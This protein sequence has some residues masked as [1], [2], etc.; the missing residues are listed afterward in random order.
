MWS[1]FFRSRNRQTREAED[2]VIAARSSAPERIL[3]LQRVLGNRAVQRL[4]REQLN[5]GIEVPFRARMEA[6]FGEN[7]GNVR[8]HLGQSA[9]L[10]ELGASAATHG[11]Q[12]AFASSDPDPHVVAHELTHVVQARRFGAAPQAGRLVSNPSDSAETE[13]RTSADRAV[14]GGRVEVSSALTAPVSLQTPPLAHGYGSEWPPPTTAAAPPSMTVFEKPDA[15]ASAE[16][17]RNALDEYGKM[18]PGNRK[19]AFDHSFKTGS[20]TKV[21]NALPATDAAET[22][23]PQVR[24]LLGWMEEVDEAQ[25]RN[26]LRRIE[27]AETLKASGKSEADLAAMQAKFLSAPAQTAVATA[28]AY[29][30]AA[31]TRWEMLTPDKQAAWTAR[32]NAAIAK[33][34]AYAAANYPRLGIT[35]DRIILDFERIEKIASNAIAVGGTNA[36]GKR[37]AV[38]GFEFVTAVEVDPAYAMQWVVHEIFGH[39]EFNDPAKANYQLSLWRKATPMVAGY[40]TTPAEEH[41]SIG[42]Q[43]SEIYSLLRQFPFFTPTVPAHK[44]VFNADPRDLID[45]HLSEMQQEWDPDVLAALLHGLYKRFAVD[46]HIAAIALAAFADLIRKRFAKYIREI[47]G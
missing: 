38:V 6:A 47:L 5:T 44:G 32:G 2:D 8:A 11:E 46:P 42:Y 24:E 39:P 21:L 31:K 33:L 43:E 16:G 20:L 28:T 3:E 41:A 14:G 15:S 23:S 12:I 1:W 17:A 10:N 35:A 30:P 7:F 25:A 9:P 36:A 22:Y 26:Y 19:T 40:A 18:A 29:K 27:E 34:V 37:A 4:V 13:A 45:W